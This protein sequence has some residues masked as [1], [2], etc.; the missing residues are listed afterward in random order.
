MP[1]RRGTEQALMWLRNKM[2]ERDTLDAINAEVC[3][4]VIMDLQEKRRVIGALYHQAH[5]KNRKRQE[6][7]EEAMERYYRSRMTEVEIELPEGW[8]QEAE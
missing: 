4:K 2:A 3:Y 8:Q 5:L 6:S 1:S 7:A